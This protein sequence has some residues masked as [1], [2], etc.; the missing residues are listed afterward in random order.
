M[1]LRVAVAAG[2][3]ALGALTWS[4]SAAQSSVFV[5]FE[6]YL[7]SL[8][9]EAAIPGLSAAIVHEGQIVWERG[10]GLQDVEE[11]QPALPDT[12]YAV[13]DLAQTLAAVMVL[14]CVEQGRLDLDD[15][16]RTWTSLI[17]EAGATVRHVLAH[18]SERVPGDRFKYDPARFAA[19]TPVIEECAGGPYAPSLARLILDRL[20]MRD[21]VPGH[22]ADDPALR[23]AFDAAALDRYRA[24]LDRLAT[25]YRTTAGAAPSDVPASG[26]TAATGLVSTVRDLAR[27][28]AAL[29][30]AVLLRPETLGLAWS[31]GTAGNGTLLPSG[32][33]WF[34]QTYQGER[35][36]WHFG[37][38]PD[39]FSS[40]ILKV[41]DRS[42][43]L[44]L[45]ANS[46]GLSAPF[47]LDG[48]DVTAS[49]FARVFLR[50]FL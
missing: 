12:P 1:S 42:L 49:L 17:P 14:Q 15:P 46:D 8:R 35:L 5:L 43:T 3:I 36:V 31:N 9:R 11:A 6:Q 33:G 32:L 41:P 18:V 13:G 10:F 25:P 39:A 50:L 40:L 28:D 22:S 44:I 37:L 30:D 45:L 23:D 27:F 19:L 48:G 47:S 16:I 21:S 7:E 4:W 2:G 38:W 26:A 29:D 34:V 20:A 24:V